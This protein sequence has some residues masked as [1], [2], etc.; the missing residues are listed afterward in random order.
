MEDIEFDQDDP[1]EIRQLRLEH[2]ENRRMGERQSIRPC[3][4]AAHGDCG[5]SL[6]LLHD[7]RRARRRLVKSG[8]EP[9]K[10]IEKVVEK[11]IPIETLQAVVGGA[12]ANMIEAVRRTTTI[13]SPQS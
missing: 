8:W 12:T 13:F 3:F 4:N 11:P 2:A 9:P 1:I 5:F 7:V 10:H 6:E